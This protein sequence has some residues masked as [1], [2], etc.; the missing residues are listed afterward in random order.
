MAATTQFWGERNKPSQISTRLADEPGFR[1]IL[2]R[3]MTL[4]AER[5]T[6]RFT[7]TCISKPPAWVI[8]VLSHLNKLLPTTN[9]A[10]ALFTAWVGRSGR[11]VDVTGSRELA[12]PVPAQAPLR[13]THVVRSPRPD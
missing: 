11:N 3:R 12:L 10:C 4:E 7:P 6:P 1:P 13:R 8:P 9:P 2:G 5:I